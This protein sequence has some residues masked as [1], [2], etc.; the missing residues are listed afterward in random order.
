VVARILVFGML[1][2]SILIPTALASP[3][4]G[5]L[6]PLNLTP[7]ITVKPGPPRVFTSAAAPTGT[8]I[9]CLSHGHKAEMK[10]PRAWSF[11]VQSSAGVSWLKGSGSTQLILPT[12]IT[13]FS[14]VAHI[15]VICS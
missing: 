6:V 13:I 1:G 5:P 8:V 15:L 9:A 14:T 3:S 7:A 12:R 11:G 4:P 10:V 2:I